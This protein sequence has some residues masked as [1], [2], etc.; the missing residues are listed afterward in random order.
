MPIDKYKNLAN[1]QMFGRRAVTVT[2]A[3]ADLAEVARAVQVT[4][5]GGGTRLDIMPPGQDTYV[6]YDPVT[7]GFMPSLQALRIGP[8]TT[9]T[10]VAIYD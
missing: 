6:T 3:D 1:V 10:V 7:V 9:A 8:S 2:P 4:G 5:V